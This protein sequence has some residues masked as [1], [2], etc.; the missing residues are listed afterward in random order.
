MYINDFL[1]NVEQK[2]EI[3][4]TPIIENKSENMISRKDPLFWCLYI[5][6]CG[7]DEYLLLKHNVDNTI[8]S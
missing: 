8:I 1:Q 2:T 4:E 7:Y 5:C 6:V 3:I